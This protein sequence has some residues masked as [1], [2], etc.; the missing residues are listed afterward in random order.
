[1]KISV[2]ILA[3][4]YSRR[5]GVHKALLAWNKS[6]NFLDRIIEVFQLINPDK[7]IVV[8]SRQLS[9]CKDI[10]EKEYS[11]NVRFVINDNIEKGRLFSLQRGLQ[12]I[13]KDSA[14]FMHNIDNPF[15]DEQLIKS[16]I[17]CY[18]EDK[19]VVPEYNSKGGH[20][21]LIGNN[22]IKKMLKH[23]N[24]SDR[25]DLLLKKFGIVKIEVK[26]SGCLIN[27]N[28]EQE[29]NKYFK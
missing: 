18:N 4:G 22:V 19:S 12:N 14:C 29:Y 11:G 15:I 1:M 21:V 7:I 9:E 28:T 3:A 2:I 27:I 23:R 13:D 16:M 25:L 26:S 10:K 5:M 20:P 6:I 17:S 8:I 24:Y